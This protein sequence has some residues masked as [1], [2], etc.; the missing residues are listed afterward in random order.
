MYVPSW[1][2]YTQYY[3]RITMILTRL[4]NKK[5]LSSGIYQYFPPHKMRI[6]LFFGAGG[7]YFNTPKAKYNIIND[8]DDDVTNLYLVVSE[9]PEELIESIST[10]PVSKS[11]LDHWKNNTPLDPV[12]KACRFLLMSN[13]TYLGKGDTIRF[14]VGNEKKNI[15]P[16][17]KETLSYLGDDRIMNED[18]RNV[19]EKISFYDTVL[20]REESFI[21]L[22]PVYLDTTHYYKVPTWTKDDTFDCFEIMS[23]EGIPA[24]MSEFDHPFILDEA[25]KRDFRVFHV[26]NRRN[27]GNRRK[28]ILITNYTPNGLLF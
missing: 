12:L 26:K 20:K 11:L 21:Y 1:M 15:I 23:N 8:L 25:K 16:K 7:M 5:S 6:T 9:R 13:F 24:A 27:I 17:I 19:I 3:T 14:S 22:D 18:F 2:A 4:G 10:M 28:E